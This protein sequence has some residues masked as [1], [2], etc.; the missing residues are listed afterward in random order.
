M[1][2]SV[3]FNVAIGLVFIYLLYSLL[4]TIVGE[5][6]SGWLGIRARIL[7]LGI[8]RMLNDGYYQKIEKEK[9]IEAQGWWA[10]LFLQEAK[11]FKQSLA[12]KFYDYPSIKFLSKVEVDQK[13]TFGQ[14][15]PSYITAENFSETLI[16]ML[17]DKGA[18]K[19][20]A[21]QVE[22]CL[23][24]NSLHIDTETIKHLRNL[25]TNSDNDINTFHSK[26]MSWFNET[27][28]RCNGWYKRRLKLILFWFG[29]LT[30]LAFNIDTIR[31]AIALANDKEAR[32][33]L[34]S[35]GV[36]LSKDSAKYN[37]F[38][39]SN[40]DSI[41]A[42]SVIDT[43]FSRVTKDINAANLILGIGWHFETLRKK[44]HCEVD[45]DNISQIA[46]YKDR[47]NLLADSLQILNQNISNEAV[48]VN[49][50]K[51]SLQMAAHDTLHK[52]E[53]LTYITNS[54]KKEELISKLQTTQDNLTG[55]EKKIQVL[56]LVIKKDSALYNKI[57]NE[58]TKIKDSTN[59][60]TDHYFLQIDSIS[61]GKDKGT[62]FISGT[63]NY[64]FIEK[65]GYFFYVLFGRFSLVGF[66]LTALALSL[67][68][69]FWF[70]VLNKLVSLRSAGVN[71]DEKKSP[72]NQ[73][74]SNDAATINSPTQITTAPTSSDN[75]KMALNTLTQKIKNEKGIVAV[76]VR[77]NKT[78]NSSFL[79]VTLENDKIK[80]YIENKY[81]N[82]EALENGFSIQVK[83]AL[84]EEI[85]VHA[86]MSGSEIGNEGLAL[87]TGTLGCYM[88]KKGSDD[89]Y[90]ISC[91]HVV[92][93]NTNWDLSPISR[94]VITG[95]DGKLLGVIEE[96][97]LSHNDHVGV[98]IGICRFVDIGN[99]Q[100][101]T[102]FVVT[103][104]HREVTPFDSVFNTDVQLYG[105]VCRLKKGKIF[106]DK[107]NAIVQY[108][109]G[110]SYLLNDVFSITSLDPQTGKKRSLTSGGDSGSI[111]MDEDGTPLGMIFGGNSNFS[112]A[113]KFTNIFNADKPYRDYFFKI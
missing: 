109:D 78:D 72:K 111:V 27:M 35:M 80:K 53:Q 49:M 4:V 3:A 106:H 105:K 96:G 45:K 75:I 25:F 59:S 61:Q 103:K 30:A 19:S 7:R 33:Q 37:D 93:D 86:V 81:G 24:F 50:L 42:R 48:T 113:F 71:P 68:A 63:R 1:F 18:G 89:L 79:V 2:D 107:I 55:F 17:S 54:K 98:D 100:G 31:I 32:N 110:K 16:N 74:S 44:D 76:A 9:N 29:F 34:V 94:N 82:T 57:N 36:A 11:E 5:M 52:I 108:P 14:T 91:W 99:A 112:Y 95:S 88:Q 77:Y 40:G 38:I 65:L 23:R 84:D 13:G 102:E 64:S 12:G 39:Y 43:G 69:P 90:F 101:N 46:K 47:L 58:A 20:K 15:K 97:F 70:G 41:H 104:Q 87:G 73:G 85:R 8:E 21:E 56:S 92:K 6:L 83:Y 62:L 28:D 67:G 66:I 60:L 51:D 26:L 22:F 10:R